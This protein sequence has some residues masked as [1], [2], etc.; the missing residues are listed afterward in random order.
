MNT[1]IR[2]PLLLPL[3]GIKGAGPGVRLK[4]REYY[5]NK[6]PQSGIFRKFYS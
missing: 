2:P 6:L 4:K 1:A 5:F 3:R